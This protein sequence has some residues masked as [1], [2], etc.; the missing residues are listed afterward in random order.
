MFT[1]SFLTWFSRYTTPDFTHLTQSSH[2][3]FPLLHGCW[4]CLQYSWRGADSLQLCK[5]EA[6]RLSHPPTHPPTRKQPYFQEKLQSQV[7]ECLAKPCPPLPRWDVLT[8]D[9]LVFI[10]R[11]GAS[12]VA[13]LQQSPAVVP[14]PCSPSFSLHQLRRLFFRVIFK[15]KKKYLC[16]WLITPKFHPN[17][18]LCPI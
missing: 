12:L 18:S 3:C 7:P 1:S 2:F 5:K 16:V 11:H 10:P 4:G 9:T 14:A 8:L 13:A 17:S 15:R 6:S